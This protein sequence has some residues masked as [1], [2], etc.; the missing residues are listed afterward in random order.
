MNQAKKRLAGAVLHR[1][2]SGWWC[3]ALVMAVAA[4]FG[5]KSGNVELYFR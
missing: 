1:T 3:P 4:L 2:M 5:G